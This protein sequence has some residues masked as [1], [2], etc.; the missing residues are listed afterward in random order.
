MD[1]HSTNK[2]LL[3]LMLIL[4][5]V[6]LSMNSIELNKIIKGWNA[7]STLDRNYFESCIKYQY[8]LKSFFCILFLCALCSYV[9]LTLCMLINSFFFTKKLLES[10]LNLLYFIFGP[11]LL[12]SS[13]LAFTYFEESA[14][15]CNTSLKD[16][17][18]SISNVFSLLFCLFFGI[19]FTIGKE[20]YFTMTLYADT[21]TRRSSGNKTLYWIFFYLVL[22]WKFANLNNNLRTSENIQNENFSNN[23]T[24]TNNNVNNIINE[25]STQDITQIDQ[26]NGNLSNNVSNDTNNPNRDFINQNKV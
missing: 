21:I 2:F 10:Y 16:K 25:N 5:S 24:N 19:L 1:N 6:L 23:V 7:A 9:I 20:F 13:I 12:F 26:Y 17:H 11:T 14:Y 22:K 4:T 3:Y 18:I 8:L 15:V